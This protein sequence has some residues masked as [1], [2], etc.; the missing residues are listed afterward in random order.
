MVAPGHETPEV[1]RVID[2]NERFTL[3][4][5]TSCS[6]LAVEMDPRREHA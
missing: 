2:V 3:V 5:K 6:W 4:E 1:E